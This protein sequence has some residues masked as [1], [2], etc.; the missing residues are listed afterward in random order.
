MQDLNRLLHFDEG[1][2]QDASDLPELKSALSLAALGNAIRYLKLVHETSNLGLFQV[3]QLNMD[4]LMIISNIS[5]S[6]SSCN[7]NAIQLIVFHIDLDSCIWML[8]L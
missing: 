5:E 8:R 6:F 2:Q 4:R 7:F 3:K 1:Q